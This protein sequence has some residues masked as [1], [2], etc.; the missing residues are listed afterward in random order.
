VLGVSSLFHKFY[1]I[2]NAAAVCGF[3]FLFNSSAN[4]LLPHL[5]LVRKHEVYNN[6]TKSMVVVVVVD[7]D[8]DVLQVVGVARCHSGLAVTAGWGG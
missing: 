4:C 1:W 3:F 8:V 2:I 5:P 6:G 7:D